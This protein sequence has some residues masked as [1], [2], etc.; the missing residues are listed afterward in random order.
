MSQTLL[1]IGGSG[2]FGG[3]LARRL[4]AE[5]DF[6]VVV[7]GRDR[8]KAAAFCQKWG[9]QPQQLDRDRPESLAAALGTLRPFLVIDAAGP[10]QA[11]GEDPYRVARAA[12]EAGSHYLDLADDRDFVAGF[13]QLEDLA[14]E[15]GLVAISGASSVPALSSA[16]ADALSEDL[17]RCDIIETA[18]LPGNRAPRGRSVVQAILSQVGQPMRVWRGGRWREQPAWSDL[19]RLDL[20]TPLDKRWASALGVPDLDLFPAR[21]GASSVVFRAGLELSVLH[22][23]LWGLGW[24]VR[25]KLLKSLAPL[26]RPARALAEQLF[27]F[28]SDRGAMAVRVMGRDKEGNAVRRC[29]TLIAEAGDGPWVPVTPA[30]ILARKIQAGLLASGARP[31]LGAFSLAE[32]EAALR[33]YAIHC[34][35]SEAP[36]ATLFEAVL[37]V[38]YARL[39]PALQDLH[40]V[41]DRRL[42]KG[43]GSVERGKGFKAWVY[44]T[45]AGVPPAA[46]CLPV[47]VE[48]RREGNSERWTRRFG[49]HCFHSRLFRRPG[50]AQNVVWERFGLLD[51]EIRLEPTADGLAYPLSRARLYG[52]ILLPRVLIPIS[53]TRESEDQSG[54]TRFDVTISLPGGGLVVRYAGWLEPAKPRSQ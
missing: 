49:R 43:E 29:W 36:A 9:G 11:Y 20:G 46:Q 18:I 25:L 41:A 50:D 30:L 15:R 1:V 48:M 7:A 27:R 3:L 45:L 47:E 35:R 28:G 42:F 52:R 51:L 10:F 34:R 8:A 2:V 24:L 14:K 26:A 17:A 40:D 5:C 19:T 32:A 21:Y 16:A 39:P 33:P 6:E 54:R 23:G 12:L 44:A 53:E 31:A 37:G 38:A 4:I 13:A 22:L